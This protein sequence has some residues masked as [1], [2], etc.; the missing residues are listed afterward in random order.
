MQGLGYSSLVVTDMPSLAPPSSTMPLIVSKRAFPVSGA[1]LYR[2]L[3]SSIQLTPQPPQSWNG[4]CFPTAGIPNWRIVMGNVTRNF[5]LI[6]DWGR[7]TSAETE[8][9]GSYDSRRSIYEFSLD[10]SMP[11]TVFLHCRITLPMLWNKFRVEG[12]ELRKLGVDFMVKM[13]ILLLSVTRG[14]GSKLSAPPVMAGHGQNREE[15]PFLYQESRKLMGKKNADHPLGKLTIPRIMIAHFM[16]NW[17]TD[18]V[19]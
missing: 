18:R 16:V 9:R 3:H 8:F 15:R 12:S 5:F 11:R 17:R 14:R 6:L 4:A 7:I 13:E 1:D 19:L 2:Q 10:L